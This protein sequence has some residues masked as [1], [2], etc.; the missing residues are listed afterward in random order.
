VPRL[1]PSGGAYFVPAGTLDGDSSLRAGGHIYVGSK[2][3]WDEIGSSAPQFDEG[4]V[5]PKLGS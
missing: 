1:H 4:P 2:A 5:P 3:A